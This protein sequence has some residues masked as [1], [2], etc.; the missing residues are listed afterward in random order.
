MLYRNELEFSAFNNESQQVSSNLIQSSDQTSDCP[1]TFVFLRKFNLSQT[2]LQCA[3]EAILDDK[4]ENDKELISHLPSGTALDRTKWSQIRD[5][6]AKKNSYSLEAIERNLS[7]RIDYTLS[8]PIW[9]ISP[10]I[11]NKCNICIR[12]QIRE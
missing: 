5:R 12:I 1:Q 8:T 11:R 4:N 3:F 9:L 10:Y 2:E 7:L 6:L